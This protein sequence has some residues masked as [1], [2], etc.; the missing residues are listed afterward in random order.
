MGHLP[1]KIDMATRILKYIMDSLRYRRKIDLLT[2]NVQ[3]T[4]NFPTAPYTP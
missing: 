4:L 2:L 3:W 1:I